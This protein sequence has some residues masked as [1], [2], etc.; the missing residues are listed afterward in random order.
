MPALRVRTRA[1]KPRGSSLPAQIHCVS[2]G[3]LCPARLRCRRIGPET[4]GQSAKS[5]SKRHPEVYLLSTFLFGVFVCV[6]VRRHSLRGACARGCPDGKTGGGAA[7]LQH[8]QV[9]AGALEAVSLTFAGQEEAQTFKSLVFR[10]VPTCRCRCRCRCRS[11][12]LPL[13]FMV[14]GP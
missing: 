1:T 3:A 7:D 2:L 11:A 13:R 9:R 5:T 10:C 4:G 6:T 14:S 8:R 12:D